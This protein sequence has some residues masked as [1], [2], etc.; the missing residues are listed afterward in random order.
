MHYREDLEEKKNLMELRQW[1]FKGAFFFVVTVFT[2]IGYGNIAP[3]TNEGRLVVLI[4]R[5]YRFSPYH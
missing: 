3:R 5:L 1:N 4:S 2:T